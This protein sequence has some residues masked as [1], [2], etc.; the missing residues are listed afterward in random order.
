MKI[1]VDA[2][3]ESVTL[4]VSGTYTAQELLE[5]LRH[6]GEARAKIAKDPSNPSGLPTPVEVNPTYWAVFGEATNGH[7]GLF[8][9]HSYFGWLGYMLPMVEAARL[10]KYL[11]EHLTAALTTTPTTNAPNFPEPQGGGLLH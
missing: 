6:I 10:A 5:L 3:S 8:L 9:R 4:E 1:E 2:I 11:N 7:S